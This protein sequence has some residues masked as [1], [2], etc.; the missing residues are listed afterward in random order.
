MW[1][2][3]F[4]HKS[5]G[6]KVVFMLVMATLK[7]IKVEQNFKRNETLNGLLWLDYKP[8]NYILVSGPYP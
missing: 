2:L 3:K 8:F 1:T 6:D 7:T 5:R 4:T